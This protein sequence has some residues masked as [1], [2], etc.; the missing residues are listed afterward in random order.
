V[1]AEG[2]H[3]YQSNQGANDVATDDICGLRKRNVGPKSSTQDAPNHPSSKATP[4]LAPSIASNPAA[5]K[6]IP[7][8]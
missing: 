8:I 4:R 1:R 7:D 5:M 6:H 2:V 3:G